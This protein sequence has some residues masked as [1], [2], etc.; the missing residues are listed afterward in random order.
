MFSDLI[1][2]SKIMLFNE[3]T[4]K[5]SSVALGGVY[6]VSTLLFFTIIFLYAAKKMKLK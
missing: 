3:K 1:A 5:I 4:T 2:P 6:F